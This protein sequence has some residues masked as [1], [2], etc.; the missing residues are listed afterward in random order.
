MVNKDPIDVSEKIGV[1][2]DPKH[3]SRDIQEFIK[4]LT[5]DYQKYCHQHYDHFSLVLGLDT[6]KPVLTF[7]GYRKETAEETKKRVAIE[8]EKQRK[9]EAAELNEYLRLKKKYA[10]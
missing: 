10:K 7:M 2:M 3:D 1:Y 6:G 5:A 8:E 9:V 4:E